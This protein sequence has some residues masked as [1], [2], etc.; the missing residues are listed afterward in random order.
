MQIINLIS[1]GYSRMMVWRLVFLFALSAWFLKFIPLVYVY[2]YHLG[3]PFSQHPLLSGWMLSPQVSIVTYMTPLLGII[4]I[5]YARQCWAIFSAFVLMLC[6]LIMLWNIHSYNDATFV[7][8]FWVS[9]WLLW[10]AWNLNRTYEVDARWAVRLGLGIVA[11]IFL[12][13]AVGKWT[14]EYWSGE[15][16]YQL[17]FLKKDLIVYAW[18][19]EN[20]ETETVHWLAC[21]FSRVLVI[22][23]TLWATV[24]LWPVRVACI[25]TILLCAMMV[26]GS[27]WML[28]SVTG[29]LIGLMFGI[30]W[31]FQHEL[32]KLDSK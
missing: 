28:Y 13:G 11:F 9:A 30:Y 19:R 5:I 32:G 4:S 27:T 18:I 24:F 31:V 12:G 22:T 6:S 3:L 1:T 23:E 29:P 17:Y 25:G 14:E 21:W 7:V 16:V 2:N 20:L 26:A 8:E 10:W 15:V